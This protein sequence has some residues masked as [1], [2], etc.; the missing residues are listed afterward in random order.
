MEWIAPTLE[1]CKTHPGILWWTFLTSIAL[2]LLTPLAMGWAIVQLPT[3]YFTRKKRPLSVWEEHPMLR[4]LYLVVK[5]LIGFILILAGI[6]MLV[7]PGQGVLTIV[8][9]M[10]LINF[11]GKFRLERWLATRPPVWR[12]LNWLR[13]KATRPVLEHPKESDS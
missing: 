5:N 10:V 7:L 2:S 3:D 8:V 9:G 12:S 11:P 13:K 4:P 6:A 1:W